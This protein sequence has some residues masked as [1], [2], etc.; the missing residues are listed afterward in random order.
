MHMNR[1]TPSIPRMTFAIMAL[2]AAALNIG[3]LVV[4]PANLE[5]ADGT[6]EPVV[7]AEPHVDS[8]R[9]PTM[10]QAARER[11]HDLIARAIMNDS[12]AVKFAQRPD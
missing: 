7:T 9:G 3:A 1:Y 4:L 11:R 6:A 8:D 12:G 5:T 10:A 2:L